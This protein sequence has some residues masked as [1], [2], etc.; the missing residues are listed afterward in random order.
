MGRGG[1]GVELDAQGGG[2]FEMNSAV[3]LLQFELTHCH[4]FLELTRKPYG[5]SNVIGLRRFISVSQQN[6]HL[7]A[8][9]NKDLGCV[10]AVVSNRIHTVKPSFKSW[11]AS[12]PSLRGT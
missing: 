12:L 3:P 8:V 1:L 10:D 9:L 7:Q 4:L 6:H 2:D 5:R 11:V